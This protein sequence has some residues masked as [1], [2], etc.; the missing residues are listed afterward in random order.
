MNDEKIIQNLL[1]DDRELAALYEGKKAT[2]QSSK[3]VS[4]K[5][6]QTRDIAGP[7]V[8][9]DRFIGFWLL[10]SITENVDGVCL[11]FFRNESGECKAKVYNGTQLN[12]RENNANDNFVNF[13]P[14]SNVG[15][16]MEAEVLNASSL[17]LYTVVPSGAV[18]IADQLTSTFRIQDEDN[19]LGFACI[20]TA[21]QTGDD[22]AYGGLITALKFIR[23]AEPPVIQRN[24]QPSLVDWNNPVEVLKY[25][26]EYN[27]Y[28]GQSQKADILNQTEYIGFDN[29]VE[30]L[31]TML[32][33]GVVREAKSSIELRKS[34]YIGVW[35]TQFPDQF[36]VTTIHTEGVHQF[37]VGYT[38]EIT[39]FS[40][41]YDI[42]NGTHKIADN[43]PSGGLVN[44]VTP[45]ADETTRENYIHIQLDT[46]DITVDY[47]PNLHGR[48]IIKSQVGP[49]TPDIGYRD[50]YAA[51]VDLV[52]N[53]FGGGT[54]TRMVGWLN[55]SGKFPETFDEL[56]AI[57]LAGTAGLAQTR[58]RVYSA[59]A[60]PPVYWNP[61][62]T[63]GNLF[64]TE[65][66]I[67]DPYGLG[68]FARENPLANY[69]I[70]LQNYMIPNKT[71]NTFWRNPESD[72]EKVEFTTNFFGQ[73]PD[74]SWTFYGGDNDFAKH[75]L[76]V[77]GIIDP[78]YLPIKK[79]KCKR[80][81]K[82]KEHK[83]HCK[84]DTVAYIRLIQEAAWDNNQF[85]NSLTFGRDDMESK[86]KSNVTAAMAALVTR[87]N[88]C[89]SKRPDRFIFDIRA[90]FGGFVYM[91]EAIGA[92]FGGNRSN[93][94]NPYLSFPG[95][96][97]R[98]PVNIATSS[99][100]SAFDTFQSNATI[101]GNLNVDETEQVFGPNAVVK[102]ADLIIL[103]SSFAA[104]GGDAVPH[105]LI[106]GDPNATV[107]YI[108]GGVKSAIVGEI[109]GRLW[110]AFQGFSAV[111]VDTVNPQLETAGGDP[112][113]SVYMVVEAGIV[114]TDQ[115][116]FF[117]N[118]KKHFIPDLTLPSWYD[119]TSWVDLGY[120]ETPDS[121]YPLKCKKTSPKPFD[122]ASWRD[123]ILERAITHKI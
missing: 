69:D 24:G 65:F 81:C 15:D 50:F 26:W 94:I 123:V 27:L 31:N 111:P 54:H 59:S 10:D 12:I 52:L 97:S 100:K 72:P 4:S 120:V 56:K 108:G 79:E 66:N 23:L 40:G 90:N 13:F 64:F 1:K 38:V 3:S 82:C 61:A 117:V 60:G 5:A 9:F 109:D 92:C 106:S 110:N 19:D 55:A 119:Q 74:D 84:K 44:T 83:Y 78:K 36:P 18:T 39:G 11:E 48:G 75:G 96:G 46:S 87:L 25:V 29:Y 35:K 32:T 103:T 118:S 37:N 43:L 17:R 86:V 80:K 88:T 68:L 6:I 49:V 101:G 41:E 89:C 30:A 33:T 14:F 58:G 102:N 21:V 63:G 121:F 85:L 22:A 53:S 95:D 51:C 2:I 122:Q 20:K 28:R 115:V 76:F 105:T 42:L 7:N 16:V 70:D 67:N 73:K 62:A 47:D 99:F 77:G 98:D 57:I 45:W 71:F 107:H 104:S 91:A 113:S 116:G 34:G 8:E 114:G 93:V 112:R